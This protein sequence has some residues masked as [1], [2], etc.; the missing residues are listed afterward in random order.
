VTDFDLE[1]I[2]A[3]L[4]GI[5][6][7]GAYG[8]YKP[9]REAADE[10]I[11]FAQTPTERVYTGIPEFD[12][13]MRGTG[14][15]ELTLIQGFTH[16]GKTLVA[17]EILLNNPDTPFV[18]FTPDET[19]P[20][21]LTKLT[22]ALHGIGAEELEQ[23]IYQDDQSARD[24]LLKTAERYSR[25]A[26]FDDSVTLVEMDRMMDET[27]DAL[28]VA[29]KG[30]M[31]D[32]AELLEDHDDVKKKLTSLKAWGKRHNVAMFVIHQASRTSG[33]A[34]RKMNIDSGAY[35]GEQQSTHV[36]GV[37]RKKYMHYAMITILEEKIANSQN[38]DAIARME[39]R[40]EELR[41]VDIPRDEDTITV[42]LVKNKR[43]PC[44]L[45][46]DMDYKIDLTTGRMRRVQ[47][48]FDKDGNPV[49][50]TKAALSILAQQ[51]RDGVVWTEPEM[52][53]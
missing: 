44:K 42:S 27:R 43:P 6:E 45:V 15:G 17:T 31:F 34:G 2:E 9:L 49:R 37:R 53:F 24:L 26:I 51:R 39:R 23:R 28:G 41:M 12:A 19:R 25:L 14:P 8:R 10:F 21:V 7:N 46:D 4:Q 50:T 29:P 48:S 47:T 11:R 18:L 3:N 40:I 5:Q 20:L 22:S 38:G 35:G 33:S 16:S 30:V 13:A 36:I 1:R 32:Y 52:E